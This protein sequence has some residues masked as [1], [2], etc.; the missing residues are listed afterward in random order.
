[1]IM[2]SALAS[3]LLAGPALAQEKVFDFNGITNIEVRNGITVNVIQGDTQS[4]VGSARSG[5]VE[6]F[7]L[8]KFGSW[9]AVNRATR[10]FIFPYGRQDD[11]ILT[12]TLPDV[13]AL[14]AYDA[15]SV[16]AI[17]FSGDRI[18]AEALDGGTLTLR[19]FDFDE[20]SLYATDNGQL[21]IT[22]ACDTLDAEAI[23][24]AHVD[25]AGLA[26]TDVEAAT[27]LAGSITASASGLATIDD[28]AGGS[29]TLSGG[30]QIVDALPE[31]E[32]D[33]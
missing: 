23:T 10:W 16:T 21:I 15:A 9:L 18:R 22:G 31:P 4:I 33:E 20:V 13:R 3:L 5:D 2:R 32:T 19:D 1:M 11:L 17:G 7:R 27:R 6:S 8:Q 26:C 25:A 14:K 30:A 29:I 28:G 12:V 24:S